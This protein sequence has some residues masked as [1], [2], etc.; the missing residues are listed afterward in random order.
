MSN[1][2]RKRL[3]RDPEKLILAKTIYTVESGCAR[4]FFILGD[5]VVWS[6]HPHQQIISCF[7]VMKDECD[8]K[9]L[10]SYGVQI[11]GKLTKAAFDRFR[12]SLTGVLGDNR[13]RN[14]A[15][16]VWLSIPDEDGTTISVVSFWARRTSITDEDIHLLRRTFG[17]KSP[18]WVD[19][20]DRKRST[21]FPG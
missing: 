14:K 8:L 10:R 12:N 6:H 4:T 18:T 3:S 5:A 9:R 20:I 11:A 2:T 1:H 16:R 19:Y 17:I 7:R 15:G 21:L 13:R